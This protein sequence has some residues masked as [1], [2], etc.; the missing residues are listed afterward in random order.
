MVLKSPLPSGL[1]T[2]LQQARPSPRLEDVLFE[3]RVFDSRHCA[4]FLLPPVNCSHSEI[5]TI[6]PPPSKIHLFNSINLC[7]SGFCM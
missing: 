5:N 1:N 6:F 4:L 3:D 7:L 2:G